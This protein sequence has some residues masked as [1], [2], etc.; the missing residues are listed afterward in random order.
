MSSSDSEMLDWLATQFVTVRTPLRYGS[1]EN[2]MGSP[3]DNDGESVPW[4]IRKAIK[5]AME[6]DKSDGKTLPSS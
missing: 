4:D 6:K 1:K 2:F 5:L 3:D